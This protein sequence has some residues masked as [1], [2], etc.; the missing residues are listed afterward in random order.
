MKILVTGGAGFI[1]YHLV[2]SLVNDDRLE[3]HV[4][5]NL[6]DYY[7]QSLK[8]ARLR[9]LERH[10]ISFTQLDITHKDKLF[11]LFNEQRFDVVIHLAAQAGVRYSIQ[12]PQ[13]YVD[14]NVCGF[15]NIL[16]ACREY[17]VKHLIYASSSS[18]Y[19]IKQEMPLTEDQMVDSPESLY[20]ATKKSNEL[21]ARTYS[22]LFKIP[23]TGLRF[24]T[25]YGSYGRPDMAYFTFTEKI[26]NGQTIDIYNHGNMKRDFTF[27]DDIVAGMIPLIGLPPSADEQFYRILNIGNNS[28]EE[29][30]TFISY[31]EEYIGKKAIINYLDMQPGDVVETYASIDKIKALTGFMPRTDLATGLKIFVDWFND[32][33]GG[34]K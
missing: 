28:P 26:R 16:E 30:M 21:F 14:S 6:N 1:G 11:A 29:L 8:K 31:L 27:I 2:K 32:Y 20:A 25:V 3:L 17:P 13:S 19:G 7:A 18:V 23:T 15:F 5:D 4:I 34:A 12:N 22:K 10:D 33:Y 24:F 9:E